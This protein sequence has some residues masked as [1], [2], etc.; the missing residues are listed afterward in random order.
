MSAV[1]LP[2]RDRGQATAAVA[3]AVLF[4]AGA[5]C[6]AA[7]WNSDDNAYLWVL[8]AGFLL[9]VTS[10]PFAVAAVVPPAGA[11]RSVVTGALVVLWVLGGLAVLV[12]ASGAGVSFLGDDPAP[13]VRDSSRDVTVTYL[14]ALGASAAAVVWALYGRL[15]GSGP[16][17]GEC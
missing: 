8:F 13:G 5:G 11:R 10:V 6:L 1:F 15:P 17:R 7:T 16:S 2:H 12:L 9:V 3:A 4:A 14:V